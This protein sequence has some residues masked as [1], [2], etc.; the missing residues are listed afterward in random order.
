[1]R[2]FLLQILSLLSLFASGAS[3]A[4][5]LVDADIKAGFSRPVIFHPFEESLKTDL[6]TGLGISSTSTLRVIDPLNLG[7][8]LQYQPFRFSELWT[9][10]QTH[11]TRTFTVEHQSAYL[12]LTPIIDI[13]L[14]HSH[15]FHY[16]M[17]FPFGW[18]LSGRQKTI[19]N[20][21]SLVYGSS[22]IVDDDTHDIR[23]GYKAIGIGLREIW[24]IVRDKWCLVFDESYTFLLND[25][26]GWGSHPAYACVQV[27]MFKRFEFGKTKLSNHPVN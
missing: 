7:L 25:I 12:C 21:Q 18:M 24:P 6:Y 10:Q 15:I 11:T 5:A 2:N 27:G 19:S 17:S 23:S 13:N 4:Q 8:A 9:D 22:S 26:S 3:H 14:G 20:S 16:Y 1:M